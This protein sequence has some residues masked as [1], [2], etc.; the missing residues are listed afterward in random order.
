MNRVPKE[1]AWVFFDVDID[2]LDHARDRGFILARILEHATL[3]EV[4]WA[5][6]VYGLP[7]IHRFL[8][9]DGHVE[10][11]DRTLSFWRAALKAENEPWASPQ[12]WRKTNAAPWHG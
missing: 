3:T 10:L 1:F 12:A 6:S 9:D 7:G 5:L 2:Q 11:S 4:R 8:R